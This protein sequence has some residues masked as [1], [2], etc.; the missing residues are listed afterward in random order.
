MVANHKAMGLLQS[1][2]PGPGMTDSTPHFHELE[3]SLEKLFTEILGT[4]FIQIRRFHVGGKDMNTR[5]F[6][7]KNRAYYLGE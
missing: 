4:H 7:Y 2:Y 3:N 5:C 1:W 6:Y